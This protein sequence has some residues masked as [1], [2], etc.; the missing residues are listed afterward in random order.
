[1]P[2]T[3]SPLRGRARAS[4]LSERIEE[5]HCKPQTS[6]Q[7]SMAED[8]HKPTGYC[9]HCEYPIDPGTCP[10][11]GSEVSPD[12]LVKSIAAVRRHRVARY[13]IVAAPLLLALA[14]VVY[15][16]VASDWT[17]RV[18]TR[19]LLPFQGDYNGDVSIELRRRFRS[20]QLTHSQ[21]QS[22]LKHHVDDPI[23]SIDRDHPPGVPIKI[24]IQ[25]QYRND[26]SGIHPG[27][28]SIGNITLCVDGDEVTPMS[29][30][31]I[32]AVYRTRRR[33]DR[34][35]VW[36]PPLE[37]GRHHITLESEFV[38]R[39]PNNNGNA[40]I[41]THHARLAREISIKGDVFDHVAMIGT[42]AAAR[43]MRGSVAA[44]FHTQS[45][46][47][48]YIAFHAL[49]QLP[50]PVAGRVLVRRRG[51]VGFV[52]VG[53]IFLSQEN[54]SLAALKLDILPGIEAAEWIAVR[55]VPDPDV[56]FLR[57]AN[58]CFDGVLVW[59]KVNAADGDGA[60]PIRSRFPSSLGQVVLNQTN[61][62]VR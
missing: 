55:V 26:V 40:I 46:W 59:E 21:A 3:A 62:E 34:D 6:D 36:C 45:R 47:G 4:S 43:Q 5:Q 14:I 15:I 31:D 25:Y 51:E 16:N 11:C 44:V 56:A 32:E 33:S 10:E 60:I 20:N 19:L 13:C 57:H 61:G 42:N 22:V 27:S 54:S 58:A 12:T 9:P 2:W 23:L 7:E 38:Y 50:S 30:R 17:R 49:S 41:Y 39:W 24:A 29:Q 1:M 48:P 35:S 28:P 52:H 8:L 53:H 18:P 37:E